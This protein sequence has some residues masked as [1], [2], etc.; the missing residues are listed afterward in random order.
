M[1][2]LCRCGTYNAIA[3]GVARAAGQA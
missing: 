3:A 1:S 2:N